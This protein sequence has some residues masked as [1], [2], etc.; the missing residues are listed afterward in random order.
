MGYPSI[1]ILYWDISVYPGISLRRITRYKMGYD[2]IS[3]HMF[4]GLHGIARDIPVS[5]SFSRDDPG[6]AHSQMLTIASKCYNQVHNHLDPRI[7]AL[8]FMR[9]RGGWP[10]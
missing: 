1:G 6:Y 5:A 2:G 10:L 3:L 7:K 8:F 9:G 4:A